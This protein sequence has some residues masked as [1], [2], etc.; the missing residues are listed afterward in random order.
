M[1]H[2]RNGKELRKGDRVTMEFDV[3]DVSIG[4]DACNVHLAAVAPRANMP[5]I[6]PAIPDL[7]S[8]LMLSPVLRGRIRI[9]SGSCP[10][11]TQFLMTSDGPIPR[12]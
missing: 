11:R 9:I 3:L 4:E 2:D 12:I 6:S 5:R 10:T 8:R 7:S 1:P